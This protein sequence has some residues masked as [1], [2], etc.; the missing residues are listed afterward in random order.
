[1]SAIFGLNLLDA[2]EPNVFFSLSLFNRHHVTLDQWTTVATKVGAN[3]LLIIANPGHYYTKY[4][5]TKVI[6]IL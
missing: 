2:N 4:Y 6:K 5:P 3:I 1:M